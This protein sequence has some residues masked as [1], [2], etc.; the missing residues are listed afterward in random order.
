MYESAS[1]SNNKGGF[2]I[3]GRLYQ[4]AEGKIFEI[5]TVDGTRTEK[6]TLG[7]DQRVDVL[8]YQAQKGTYNSLATAET[9]SYSVP[10]FVGG[11]PAPKVGK[12]KY[13]VESG[14]AKIVM[15]PFPIDDHTALQTIP[16]TT[17]NGT[18]AYPVI[19]IWYAGT[20]GGRDA[21]TG[22]DDSGTYYRLEPGQFMQLSSEQYV[23][24]VKLDVA[25]YTSVT[26]VVIASKNQTLRVYDGETTVSTVSTAPAD[27][28]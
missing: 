11:N 28:S 1:A 18:Y 21:G 9:H 17:N 20:T 13:V 7:Y 2:S 26:K 10:T 8:N 27:N 14:V 24:N 23:G 12:I 6:A 3:N 5:S 16:L 25:Y 19:R 22:R 15:E 4:I